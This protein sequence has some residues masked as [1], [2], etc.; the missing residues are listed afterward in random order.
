MIS[1]LHVTK[2]MMLI[3]IMTNEE[4]LWLSV[5]IVESSRRFSN[6]TVDPAIIGLENCGSVP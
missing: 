4:G 2:V 6:C 3:M 1:S 5:Q